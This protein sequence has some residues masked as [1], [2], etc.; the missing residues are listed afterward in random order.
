[1]ET[2]TLQNSDGQWVVCSKET[3]SSA[4]ATKATIS[5]TDFSIVDR[6]GAHSYPIAGYSWAMVYQT[7]PDKARA[8]MI[9]DVLEWIVGPQAQQIAGSLNYV[10]LPSGVQKTAQQALKEMV[11]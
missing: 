9:H 6:P 4:A 8:R 11:L 1:M 5:A 10:P 7:N 2:A 3:V